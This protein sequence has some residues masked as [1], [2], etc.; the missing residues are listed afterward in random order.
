M[1]HFLK[2]A[3]LALAAAAG[4][5]I[6][7]PAVA[8]PVQWLAAD[9]GNDHWY[10]YVATPV[11]WTTALSVAEENV[12]RGL[13]GYLV[14]VTSAAEYAFLT[15]LTNYDNTWLAGTDAAVEGT[16]VWAAG[17][18]T[19]EVFWKDNASI[20]YAN[21][22]AFEPSNSGGVEDYVIG[23]WD[24]DKWGDASN[25]VANGYIV[26]YGGLLAAP[27]PAAAPLLIAALGGLVVVRRRRE[28]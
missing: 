2:S 11:T 7:H 15:P 12:W 26:E 3:A 25:G 4:L 16:W 8:A 27:L 20:T 18:E 13:Q 10:E 19:G 17:P 9:G 24:G 14:T 6:P 5:S 23:W 1:S 28:A 22:R 21:W